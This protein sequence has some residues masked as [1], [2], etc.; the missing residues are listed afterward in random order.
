MCLVY[1]LTGDVRHGEIISTTA[2]VRLHL[3]PPFY[4]TSIRGLI[5]I[6]NELEE[7]K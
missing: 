1:G 6:Q 3:N 5:N 7:N 2:M 4:Q